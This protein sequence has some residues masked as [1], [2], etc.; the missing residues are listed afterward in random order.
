MLLGLYIAFF[1]SHQRIWLYKKNGSSV[2]ELWLAGSANK[3]KMAFA[4]GFSQLKNRIEHAV[5]R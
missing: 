4:K 3:N 1:M 5:Q 2:P